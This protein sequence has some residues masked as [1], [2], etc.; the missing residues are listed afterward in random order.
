MSILKLSS[1]H[2]RC[3]IW[4]SIA[5]TTSTILCSNCDKSRGIGDTFVLPY[6]TWFNV[7]GRNLITGLTS[8]ASP[9]VGIWSTRKVGQKLGVSPSVDMLPFGMTIPAAVPQ[10]SEIPERLMIYPV[11]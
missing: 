6:A 11:Y 1:C 2:T 7:C 5:T 3:N 8:A 10:R 9:R 4:R